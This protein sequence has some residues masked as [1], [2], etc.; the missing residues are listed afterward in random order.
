[1]RQPSRNASALLIDDMLVMECNDENVELI[2]LTKLTPDG[3]RFIRIV[4]YPCKISSFLW[5]EL[6]IHYFILPALRCKNEVEVPQ[7]AWLIRQPK[8]AVNLYY[9]ATKTDSAK[10]LP[11]E[12]EMMMVSET[13]PGD[14]FKK[15]IAKGRLEEAEVTCQSVR[16]IDNV[17]I[18]FNLHLGFR[19][20]IWVKS[21]ADIRSQGQAYSR[22]IMQCQCMRVG[23]KISDIT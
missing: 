7:H 17:V 20:T 16:Y 1:M 10:E 12:M 3:D 13:D 19:K 21:A 14:R 18:N 22:G 6:G 15:L 9:L 5:K 23:K 2:I 11:S 8:S 4:E